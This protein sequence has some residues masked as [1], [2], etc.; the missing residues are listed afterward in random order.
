MNWCRRIATDFQIQETST[1][2]L[3]LQEAL[4]CFAACIP[5]TQRRILVAQAIGAKLNITQDRVRSTNT[6]GQS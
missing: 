1:A 5:N 4:D 3:V 6:E 2:G